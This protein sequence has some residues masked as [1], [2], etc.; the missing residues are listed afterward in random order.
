M[1]LQSDEKIVHRTIG[2]MLLYLFNVKVFFVDDEHTNPNV[3]VVNAITQKRARAFA[4]KENLY[5]VI[6]V[7]FADHAAQF[8][9]GDGR[10]VIDHMP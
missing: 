2:G 5:G 9:C 7:P 1:T 8:G 3:V 6:V 10:I 4:G